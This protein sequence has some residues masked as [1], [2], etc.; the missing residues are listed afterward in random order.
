[1]TSWAVRYSKVELKRSIA[2]KFQADRNAYTE[3]KSAF[4][5][6]VLAEALPSRK[7]TDESA[8]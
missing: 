6:Q 4:V 2:Q 7:P 1:L 5:E 8:Q 3:A